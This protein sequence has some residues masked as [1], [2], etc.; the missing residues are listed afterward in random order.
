MA[1]RDFANMYAVS[2]SGGTYSVGAL[3]TTAVKVGDTKDAPQTNDNR[4]FLGDIANDHFQLRQAGN[5]LNG[6]YSFVT[7][8]HEGPTSG[9]IA[10]DGIHYYFFTDGTVPP[11]ALSLD[12]GLAE[13][14]CFMP[15]TRIMTPAGEV[16]V[17]N[18]TPGDLVQT[19]EGR[20]VPVRW[21]GRQTV[22]SLFADELHLPVRI[23]AGALADNV[24]SRDLLTSPDHAFLVDGILAHAG[25]LVNGTSIVREGE[26]PEKFVY[27]HVEV[28]D[29]S[30]VLAENVPAETF[31]DNV[32]R[33]RF[34]NWDEYQA[35]NPEGTTMTELPYP[36]A[37]AYRQVPRATRNR[38]EQ[39]GLAL[40]GQGSARAA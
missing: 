16:P 38:L 7:V 24:P 20:S 3:V 14:M 2:L 21:I 6:E 32:D 33:Q 29:H 15:G 1:H 36:R 18:L 22:A 8:A 35:L 40:Y 17:E 13:V 37:K 12:P 19:V 5:A 28:A 34:D 25:A 4:N 31:I 30:L 39:R 9:F 23:R 26:V 27:Y 11:G 10:T